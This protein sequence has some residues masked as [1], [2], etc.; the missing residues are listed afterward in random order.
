MKKLFTTKAK[1]LLFTLCLS[2]PVAAG[3]IQINEANFPDENF[4]KWL[5]N[6]NYGKDGTLTEEEI[7]GIDRI[8]SLSGVKDLTGIKYFTA[9]TFL[10][11]SYHVETLDIAGCT[12][13]TTLKCHSSY[14]TTLD[15][16]GCTA[17]TTLECYSS[18]LTT[19]SVSGCTALR[20]IGCHGN[21]L[22]T[23]DVSGCTALIELKCFSN[24]L[25]TLDASGCAALTN[26]NCE[27]NQLTNLNLSGCTALSVLTCGDNQLATLD[28]SE[29]AALSGL[30][31]T[32]NQLTALDMSNNTAL[33]QLICV[34]NQLTAID[35]TNNP[36][37]FYLMCYRNQLKGEKLDAFIS[38]LPQPTR[39]CGL[40][41]YD[42]VSADEGNVCT[43]SQVA[44]IREKG[45]IPYYLYAYGK[46]GD[47]QFRIY[48]DDTSDIAQP[49]T[50]T[51]DANAP[52]YTLSG[53]KASDN[54][55]GKKGIYIVGGKK[56]V[57]K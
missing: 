54:L 21:K 50:E 3:S 15:V 9:L 23:L 42:S 27:K 51:V 38:S 39:V 46:Y 4:R 56:I 57:I 12:T 44:A 16:S 17:L 31:C 22:T 28:I 52:T 5:L 41:V 47:E 18:E 30:D 6:Q 32:N 20:T 2:T 53:Q 26:L 7:A 29:C 43:N 55:K 36:N 14:L 25:T 34:G 10:D 49:T 13:L 35:V 40:F 45:W 1:T 8:S 11:C 24:Q 33:T 37:I 19:L 48:D